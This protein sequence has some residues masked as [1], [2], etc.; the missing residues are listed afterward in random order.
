MGILTFQLEESHGPDG[1]ARLGLV[2]ELDLAVA[3][4]LLT[5]IRWL[6]ARGTPVRIDL[7]RLE[8]IDSR[9]MYALIRAVVLGREGR[10]ELVEIDRELS[11]SVRD[12][13]E[14]AGVARMLW[15]RG[16]RGTAGATP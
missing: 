9:G 15:P 4:Q 6:L 1:V 14:L 16:A 7:S 2:G 10:E 13:L 8:F 3:D 11:A 5:R 12:A